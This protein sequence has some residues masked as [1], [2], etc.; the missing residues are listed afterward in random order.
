MVLDLPPTAELADVVTRAARA[1]RGV[2]RRL[3]RLLRA[4]RDAGQ[5]G[6][7]RGGPGH[8]PRPGHRDVLVRGEQADGP[9]RRRVLRQRHQRHARRRGAV[10]LS[11]D[12]RVG[13]V[14]DRVLGARGGQAP[15]HAQAEAAGRPDRV[16][17]RRRLGHRQGH[18]PPA[19]RG[20]RLRRRGRH[21]R[22]RTPRPSRASSAGPTSPSA[23][24]PTSPTRSRSPMPSGARSSPSA[25]SI[26]SSTTPACRSRSRCSRRPSRD[27]DLQHDVMARGSFLVSR[28]AARIL[29]DQAMGGDLVYIVSKNAFFA[30]PNNVAYGAAKADQAHQVRLLAA[31]LGQYGHPG[32]RRQPRRG[33]PRLGHLRQGLGRRPRPDLRHR[34]G[35]ARRVLRA[36]HAAQARGPA[37]ACRGRGLR[38][39]RRRPE[40]DDRAPHPRRRGCRGGLPPVTGRLVAAVDLGASSGRVMVGRVA[41]NELELTEVHRFPNDPVRLPDGLH[42]DILRLYHEVLAGLREAARTAEAARRAGQRRG[43]FVG[44]RLRAARRG[45]Q[46]A[47]ETRTTTATDETRRASRPST[48]SS[49]R[50]RSTR[51]TVC[52]SCRSTRST[53]CG[54]AGHGRVRGR[55]ADA[56]DPG[57]HR[58]VAVGRRGQRGHERI[59][60]RV[61]RRPSAHLGHRSRRDRS[62]SPR[63]CWRRSPRRATSSGRCSTRPRRDRARRRDAP[64]PRRVARHRVGGGRRARHASPASPTSP[65]GHGRWSASSSTRRS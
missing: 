41:P 22:R 49:R 18:R 3:C 64:D 15:A 61:A 55:A 65:A 54:L 38:P 34:R 17:D 30:G 4:L 33:R 60:D 26:S 6:D 28:E 37:G 11:P 8:R 27:W 7:A 12:R 35:Q 46:P 53:S 36:A 50:T 24:V 52:R 20:G 57:P 44:G 39:D 63:R 9:R 29:I 16:R 59:L 43:R 1:P 23:S 58:V 31:E 2:P 42:W 5:P 25:G 48:R 51:G 21:R 45:R 19:R 47:R 32:Q 14:P 10:D 62:A 40:P 56:D 13:E